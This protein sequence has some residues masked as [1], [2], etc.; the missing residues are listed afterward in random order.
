MGWSGDSK[1]HL[2]ECQFNKKKKKSANTCRRFPHNSK[3]HAAQC[4]GARLAHLHVN[5]ALR[6]ITLDWNKTLI[7][8][9]WTASFSS[10]L[11]LLLRSRKH[12]HALHMHVR[13]LWT[14]LALHYLKVGN[15]LQLIC[16]TNSQLPGFMKDLICNVQHVPSKAVTPVVPRDL[17]PR[18]PDVKI[19][20]HKKK[21]FSFI[22]RTNQ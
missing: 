5:K 11:L 3:V 18:G 10:F 9:G 4:A 6:H 13:L 14:F 19:C 20:M 22:T 21:S 16:N 7:A 8:W 12:T 15:I 2:Y 1:I 17:K